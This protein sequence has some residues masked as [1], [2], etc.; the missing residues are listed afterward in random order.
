[1]NWTGGYVADIGY[2]AGF[3][4]E[5]APNHLAFAALSVARSPGRALNPKRVLEL[6]FGQGLGLG[7]I[8]AANPDILFEGIDFNPEHVAHAQRLIE[9][10]ELANVKVVE[11]GFEEAA[12]AGGANDLD[13]I[14]QHGIFSWVGRDIQDA[15]IAI[16]RQRLQP[17]GVAYVSY[18]C[19]PG[20]AALA[21]IRQFMV[22]IKRRNPG[23][24]ERQI[25]LG[26]ELLTKLRQGNA[27][28]FE[29]NPSA[30]NHL[31]D[32]LAKSPINLAH[33]YLGEHTELFQFAE[34]EARLSEAKLTYVAS[35]TLPENFL[36]YSVPPDLLPLVKGLD[37]PGL[38]QTMLDYCVNKRFR[39]DIFARGTAML[40]P[41]EHRQ[42]LSKLSLT[43]AV[44]RSRMTFNFPGPLMGLIGRD[45]LY[46]PIADRLA[47]GNANFDELL[48]LPVFGEDKIAVL[49]D[50]VALLV[51]SNQILPVFGPA[52][53]VAPAQRFNRMIVD[54]IRA[55]RVYRHLAAPVGRT[56][57]PVTDFGLFAL[58]AVF[59]GKDET[60][61]AA[62][63][64][65]SI[66]KAL[67]R[68][69]SK[70]GRLIDD[71]RAATSFLAENIDP[72]LKE[73]I[74][75]WRRLGVF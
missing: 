56:G 64:A 38:R 71:D 18:N 53:D 21:P 48:A 61:A 23:R 39:R 42:L 40:T 35:A 58:A 19:M 31:D 55:G 62:Q 8:A 45:D 13:V 52:V 37:D 26:L 12:A 73:Y 22:E 43:L 34:V 7:I 15:I 54:Q 10:A 16:L 28:Y 47:R 9:G 4:G 29:V 65:M 17:D 1:M 59:E 44:P 27:A 5:T 57:I 68:R 75:V 11:I 6:G 2:S 30:R 74:P 60:A 20:W 70:D 63:M 50:C 24:S 49:L 69:P 33:E 41:S 67:G 72:I 3:Y 32:M 36:A 66:L 46:S 25:A 51:Y 14:T